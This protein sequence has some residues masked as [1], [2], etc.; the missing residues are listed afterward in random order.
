MAEVDKQSVGEWHQ[1][2]AQVPCV[3]LKDRPG[4]I[5][6]PWRIAG[7]RAKNW[8]QRLERGCR[9]IIPGLRHRKFPAG[10]KT[11]RILHARGLNRSQGATRERIRGMALT[12]LAVL[13]MSIWLLAMA[14]AMAALF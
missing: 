12:W 3:L 5:V 9:G 6:D 10:Q 7:E 1:K 11:I 4:D 8:A 13:G 14:M 2:A